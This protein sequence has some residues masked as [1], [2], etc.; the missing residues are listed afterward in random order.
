MTEDANPPKPIE[1]A[2]PNLPAVQQPRRYEVVRSDTDLFDTAKFEHIAR[3]AQ[4]H[5]EGS[6][7]PAPLRMS[8]KNEELGQRAVMANCL[9]VASLANDWGTS[10]MAVA[11]SISIV[12]GKPMFEGK[13]IAAIIERKL[14]LRLR[15]TWSGEP[16]TDGYGIKVWT[17]EDE[18]RGYEPIEGTVGEWKTKEKSGGI[19]SIWI[20]ANKQKQQLAY[21]G[22][23]VWARL[24][25]PGLILG[26]VGSDEVDEQPPPPPMMAPKL[27]AGFA[28]PA[29]QDAQHVVTGTF[30]V[31]DPG[32]FKKAASDVV[33]ASQVVDAAK[34]NPPEEIIEQEAQAASDTKPAA[35]IVETIDKPKAAEPEKAKAPKGLSKSMAASFKTKVD[36]LQVANEGLMKRGLSPEAMVTTQPTTDEEAQAMIGAI[37][38]AIVTAESVIATH[39]REA[40]ERRATAE[41]HRA[42]TE[43]AQG[44]TPTF[45]QISRN[46][47]DV[48]RPCK[49]WPVLKSQ[50]QSIAKSHEW[51]AFTPAQKDLIYRETWNL[52]NAMNVRELGEGR[53]MVVYPHADLTAYRCAVAAC[54]DAGQLQDM[55]GALTDQAV[56][57]NASPANQAALEANTKARLTEL[58]K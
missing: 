5:A 19:K 26:V 14:G 32:G 43:A 39:D 58:S 6:F 18:A 48:M 44:E 20:G 11:Q 49:D 27:T 30:E 34:A 54:D 53:Q 24:N 7:L 29:T 9:I 46:M 4:A 3:V 47:L 38:K 13:L 40:E 56:W 16:G 42:A 41:A 37:N 2:P 52:A 8:E 35:E 45:E 31:K 33:K 28:G 50:L 23:R 12:H 22:A 51:K 21:M 57:K 15:Y 10:F 25:S 36:A 1:P 17:E 55:W